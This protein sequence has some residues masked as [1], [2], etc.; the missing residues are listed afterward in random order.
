M[1]ILSKIERIGSRSFVFGGEWAVLGQA[2]QIQRIARDDAGNA[3][4][5]LYCLRKQQ[6]QYGYF[7]VT[8]PPFAKRLYSAACALAEAL[9]QGALAA[10]QF[11]DFVWICC[12]TGNTIAVENGDRVFLDQGEARQLFSELLASG[13]YRSIYAPDSWSIPNAKQSTFASVFGR[14]TGP[15]LHRSKTDPKALLIVFTALTAI[16]AAALVGPEIYTS[17]KRKWFSGKKAPAQIAKVLAPKDEPKPMA[18][19]LTPGAYTLAFCAQRTKPNHAPPPAPGFSLVY[20]ECN[21]EGASFTY[22]ASGSVPIGAAQFNNPA[23]QA[24][25]QNRTIVTRE[26]PPVAIPSIEV[27]SLNAKADFERSLQAIAEALG[28]NANLGIASVL[29]GSAEL[30]PWQVLPFSF[31]SQA[32]VERYAPLLSPFPGMVIRSITYRA[33]QRTPWTVQGEIYVYP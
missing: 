24:N 30:V 18:P 17:V 1:T 8:N 14:R 4:A 5:S 7:N 20:I 29:P 2:K 31:T 22:A 27:W 19:R 9:P 28:G 33:N 16:S 10:F 6:L 25:Y 21:S 12:T 32:P 13:Q 23:A 11:K 3:K 26:T 15:K